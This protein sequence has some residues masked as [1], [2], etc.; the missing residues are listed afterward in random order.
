[1]VGNDETQGRRRIVAERGT[2]NAPYRRR[3]SFTRRP[4]LLSRRARHLVDTIVRAVGELKDS[5]DGDDCGSFT[6]L[7]DA[8]P[9][10]WSKSEPGT[11][12][13][14]DDIACAVRF[15]ARLAPPDWHDRIKGARCASV[16][17][18]CRSH[19][20]YRYSLTAG[21]H[22]DVRGRFGRGDQSRP[23]GPAGVASNRGGYL[24]APHR[25]QLSAQGSPRLAPMAER[26]QRQAGAYG[27]PIPILGRAITQ[28]VR[29][30]EIHSAA[31]IMSVVY[32]VMGVTAS[33]TLMIR[34]T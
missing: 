18:A 20:R 22:H 24:I 14:F 3:L 30:N 1:M 32:A 29:S 6:I 9:H 8:P 4:Q 2:T 11:L 19:L 7:S 13:A 12:F 25:R 26:R 31:F 23:V 15:D 27:Q 33:V 21:R 28:L 16:S 34:P 17:L 5:G 10:C